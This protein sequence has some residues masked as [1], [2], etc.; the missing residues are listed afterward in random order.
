[1]F[2]SAFGKEISK[3]VLTTVQGLSID[4]NYKKILKQ[5]SE[6]YYNGYIVYDKELEKVNQL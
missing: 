4:F 1:M 5:Q 2:I 3:I 6:V